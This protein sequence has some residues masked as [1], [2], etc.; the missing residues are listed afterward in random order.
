[1]TTMP[2]A[3]R[4]DTT[5]ATS[6]RATNDVTAR[7]ATAG[8]ATTGGGAGPSVKAEARNATDDVSTAGSATANSVRQII[9]MPATVVRQVADDVA[10]TARRPDAV[11]YVGGLLGLAALGVLEWPVAAVAGVGVAVANGVRRA[12]A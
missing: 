12:R 10:S 5:T 1:M 11:V 6:D 7:D 2:T 4:R 8:D 9:M 3:A